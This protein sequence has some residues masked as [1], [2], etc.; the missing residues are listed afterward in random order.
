LL[1]DVIDVSRFPLPA[2]QQQARFS[3]RIG[4]GITGLADALAMLG[5]RYDT[6]DARQAAARIMRLIRDSAYEV[7]VQL[8]VEKGAC[9]AFDVTAYL[10]R[11][12]IQALPA[13]LRNAIEQ[14]GI[15]NSHLTA[16]APAGTISLLAQNVSCGVEP[17]FGIEALHRIV[18]ADGST[19][20]IHA[21]DS[22]YALWRAGHAQPAP[23]PELFIDGSSITPADHLAM[24]A[25]LQPYVDSAI[26]KTVT[27]P[28]DAG[29]P[30]AAAIL[31]SA[32][33]LGLK[34]CTLY[35]AQARAAVIARSREAETRGPFTETSCGIDR[36]CD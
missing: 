21:T 17:M 9:P 8:A 34:G 27:L 32:F 19:H 10:R 11:P 3:R 14:H 16:I 13:P 22:A 5:L 33:D 1:D 25:A 24:Q 4:L 28:E 18:A 15:R 30:V 23:V 35:R 2:Q 31:E 26:S 6:A 20:D 29:R 36:E 12:F 7:S